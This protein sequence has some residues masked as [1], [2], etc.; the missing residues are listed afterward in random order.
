MPLVRFLYYSLASGNNMISNVIQNILYEQQTRI[1]NLK[2]AA[3]S[4]DGL[5]YP[6]LGWGTT[7]GL[8]PAFRFT[9]V[10][11]RRDLFLLSL[12]RPHGRGVCTLVG[13]FT[14]LVST[15]R[16]DRFG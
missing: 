8:F 15:L 4:F 16:F 1:Y 3:I 10:I 5:P 2:L 12:D 13:F 9:V 11:G 14:W 7:S 6:S